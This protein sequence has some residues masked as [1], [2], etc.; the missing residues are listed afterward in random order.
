MSLWKKSKSRKL[1]TLVMASIMTLAMSSSVL[2]ADNYNIY[3]HDQNSNFSVFIGSQSPDHSMSIESYY[4]Y[5]CAKDTTLANGQTLKGG[6]WY[7]YSMLNKDDGGGTTVGR[8]HNYHL[9]GSGG[10]SEDELQQA[11]E[12]AIHKVDGDQTV[13]G[14]QQVDGEQTVKSAKLNVGVPTCID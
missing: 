3:N 12:D 2:A 4:L 8:D 13:T 7:M 9:L 11:I 14:D 5:W 1:Q 10:M 6:N